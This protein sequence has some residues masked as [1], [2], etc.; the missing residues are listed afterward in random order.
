MKHS[1]ERGH[2]VQ[3]APRKK[4]LQSPLLCVHGLNTC[5]RAEGWGRAA[6]RRGLCASETRPVLSE[7]SFRLGLMALDA[8]FPDCLLLRTE[9]PSYCPFMERCA[10]LRASAQG[11]VS[12]ST[13]RAV[14][15]G[16]SA[17]W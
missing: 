14:M 7:S 1:S 16:S 15:R 3:L 17:I 2:F 12:L 13:V 9:P 4:F 11:S 5:V 10:R 6:Q 8:T